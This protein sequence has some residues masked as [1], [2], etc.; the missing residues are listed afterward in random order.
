[1][2]YRFDQLQGLLARHPDTQAQDP[3]F[4][5]ESRTYALIQRWQKL[6]LADYCKIRHYEPGWIYLTQKGLSYLRLPVRFLDPYHA[7]LDHLF[8]T[9]ETRVLVEEANGSRPGFQWESERLY[10]TTRERLKAR[11]RREPDLSIPL[12]YRGFH[13]PDALIRY[14]AGKEPDDREIV[15]AI[16]AEVSEKA[17]S[18]WHAIF[19]DLLQHMHYA[20]YYV[21]P[22]I[23]STFTGALTK[24][25]AE[26]PGWD[27]PDREQRQ[28][29]Y[30]HDLTQVL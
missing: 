2:A 18:T 13:R 10:W 19:I 15:V 3:D 4:L 17:Y 29:I 25:Q 8:W 28:H 23:L 6:G 14:R 22:S 9:N 21:H 30:I 20:N 12:E 24:F 26:A 7:D 5:S 11:K 16:E 1:V 27:E